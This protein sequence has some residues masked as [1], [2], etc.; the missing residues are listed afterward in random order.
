MSHTAAGAEATSKGVKKQGM[1]QF[2]LAA[3]LCELVLGWLVVRAVWPDHTVAACRRGAIL[4]S[5]ASNPLCRRL[6]LP[7]PPGGWLGTGC[8]QDTA[9]CASACAAAGTMDYRSPCCFIIG[10][11]LRCVCQQG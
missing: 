6:Q 8:P 9:G 4:S 3:T 5:A 2:V 10:T 7:K 1:L 11:G